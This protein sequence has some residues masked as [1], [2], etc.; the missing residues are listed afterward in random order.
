MRKNPQRDTSLKAKA[1]TG[2]SGAKPQRH[3]DFSRDYLNFEKLISDLSALFVNIP[4]DQVDVEIEVALKQIL[5]FF[6]VDR[7]GLLGI[8]PDRKRVHVTHAAYAENIERVSGDIDLAALFPWS[9]E[10]LVIQGQPVCLA[11]I[12]ELP[13][14]A[15]KDKAHYIAMNMRSLLNIPLFFEGRVSSII[16]INSM[17]A[18]RSWPE[19]FIPRLRLL[20]EIFINAVKRG[21]AD[22]ALRESEVRLSLATDAAGV[23]PW[24]IE[25]ASGHIW[26]TEKGKEFF[27]F[28]RDTDLTLESFLSIVHAEDRENLRRTVE[29]TMQSGK[30]NSAEYRIVHP[31]GKIKW[32][33]SRG[34]PYPTSSGG[35]DRLMGVSID[36]TERKTMEET[37]R[38]S[39][40]KFRGFFNSTPDYCYIIS[41]QGTILNINDSALQM[42]GYGREEIVGKPLAII[43]APESV[44]KMKD[45]F[46]KW[47]ERGQIINEEVTIITKRGER[48]TVLLNAGAVRD[49]DG[50]IL[51]STSVQNDI[52]IRKRAEEEL[53]QSRE[54]FR[55]IAEN[56]SDF[57]W[58]VAPDGLYSYTSPS[59]ERIL[60][61][62]ADELIGKMHFYDLFAPNV[63]K[64]L[65]AAA[66]QV[67]RA[68]Q[69]FRAFPNPNV[70]KDGKIVHLETSGIP[71]LD[72]GGNLIGYRGA[73]TD[74]TERKHA[75]EEVRKAYEEIKSLKEKLELENVCLREEM[76]RG[77]EFE[78]IVGQSD[79]LKYVFFRIQQVAPT[80]STVLITGETGTGKGLVSRAIHEASKRRSQPMVVVN[81]A[82]LPETLIESE[83]FGS[84]KGAFTGADKSR[85]G[86]F[87]L[88]DKG[89]IFLDEVGELPLEL[90]AKLL[91]VIESG[92]FERLGSPR[93]TRVD[94]R[95]IASTNRDLT[96]EVQEGRFREDL[97]YRLNVFPITMPPL[98]QR[99][100]DI[101]VLVSHF[102]AKHCKKIGKSIT[103]IPQKVMKAL[104]EF[105]WPGNV[106]ELENVIARA[107]ISTQ[108]HVLELAE[109]FAEARTSAVQNSKEGLADVERDHIFRILNQTIWKIEGE[110]G[111]ARI[112]GLRPST[113]R[114]RM[115]KLDIRRPADM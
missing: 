37:L 107:V 81:C 11:R 18:E 110:N 31:D 84:E 49:K 92:E 93:T 42:L 64:D 45:L 9:Y 38:A 39:E 88:A 20:G 95:I 82:A 5:D 8:T 100:D 101:P 104:E 75:E 36:V 10:K 61:Y 87:A 24:N 29:L 3:N 70:S 14:T 33:L 34:R 105:S 72:K 89:T 68:K 106:R 55:D 1:Q 65:K 66:F 97:F 74:V 12:E 52:T 62:S 83:L 23:M 99:A 109:P 76:S 26:T 59:V 53:K 96:K 28:S 90:Q 86:R 112:L 102:V 43:Y 41:P 40:E 25:M 114:S 46:S 47:R 57:I 15:Q 48:R 115:K 16:V 69:P 77:S 67:F 51:Y 54:R 19:I 7:C 80:D 73:D 60:G 98:R 21:D 6:Q 2:R 56:V 27:G 78:S 63:R 94:V 30:E 85:A 13:E 35:G 17:H 103:E 71:V 108:G 50:T 113:L 58:E 4:P 32:V 79:A 22:R 44:P 111:A 91:R